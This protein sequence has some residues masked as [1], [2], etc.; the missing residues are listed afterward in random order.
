MSTSSTH[1]DH[2]LDAVVEP[3]RRQLAYFEELSVKL[4]D[5]VRRQNDE[6]AQLKAALSHRDEVHRYEQEQYQQYQQQQQPPPPESDDGLSA[7]MMDEDTAGIPD[8][9]RHLVDRIVRRRVRH[10]IHRME[11]TMSRSVKDWLEDLAEQAV[12][13]QQSQQPHHHQHHTSLGDLTSEAGCEVAAYTTTTTGNRAREWA[14]RAEEDPLGDELARVLGQL[15]VDH[16]DVFVDK[17]GAASSSN[18]LRS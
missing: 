14:R 3:L 13:R 18:Y 16:P 9:V 12:L 6:I 15:R 4:I 8:E 17:G 7:M 10:Y 2:H 11:H 5:Q 1:N